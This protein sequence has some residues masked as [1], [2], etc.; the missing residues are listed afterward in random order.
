MI[1]SNQQFSQDS[2]GPEAVIMKG[3]NGVNLQLAEYEKRG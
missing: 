3:V 1:T 2:Y